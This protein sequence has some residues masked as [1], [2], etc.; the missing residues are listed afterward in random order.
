MKVSEAMTRDVRIASPSE[1]IRQAA[2]VMARIDAGILPVGE[3]DRL[4]G[5]ITDRDIA[6]RAVAAGKSPDTPIRE[7][8]SSD[9]VC[10]CFEDQEIDDVASNMAEIKVRRLPVVSR[11]KRLV[12]ILSLGDISQ[13]GSQEQPAVEALSGICEP[14]GQHSQAGSG[15][16]RA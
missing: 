15:Q 16:M 10:Y 7:V 11:E 4:V 9:D 3:N 8:M 5:M 12:G 14:G 13:A 2:Q 1:T 6:V